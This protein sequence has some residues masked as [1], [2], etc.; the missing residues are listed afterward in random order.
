MRKRRREREAALPKMVCLPS[1][2]GVGAKVMKNCDPFVLG[3]AFAILRIPAPVCLRSRRISSS[4]F[5]LRADEGA[6]E[7]CRQRVTTHRW[8]LLRLKIKEE[9]ETS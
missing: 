1:S 7:D 3:P 8:T 6:S 9:D 2:H 5:P 4:N